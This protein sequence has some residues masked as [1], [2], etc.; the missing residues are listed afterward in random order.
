MMHLLDVGVRAHFWAVV[1]RVA[2]ALVPCREA[3][4][5]RFNSVIPAH[6]GIQGKPTC[7]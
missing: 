4:F 5:R 6:A 3:A 1:E 7:L 2:S